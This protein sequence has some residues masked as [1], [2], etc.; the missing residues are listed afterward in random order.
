[1]SW[2]I[3]AKRVIATPRPTEPVREIDVGTVL[4]AQQ[5]ARAPESAE[6]L[7]LVDTSAPEQVLDGVKDRAGVRLDRDPILGTEDVEIR[8][9]VI[10]VATEAHDA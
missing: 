5:V 2:T 7:E 1:M 9:A 6:P 10:R 4:G 8:S 3:E